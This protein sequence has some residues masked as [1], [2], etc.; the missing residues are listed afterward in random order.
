MR[1]VSKRLTCA[2]LGFVATS[3]VQAQSLNHP[4]PQAPTPEPDPHA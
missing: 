2:A 4:G 3:V 1:S